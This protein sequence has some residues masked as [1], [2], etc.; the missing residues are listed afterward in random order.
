MIQWQAVDE[1][2]HLSAAGPRGPHGRPR[3]ATDIDGM[4][5]LSTMTVDR[6]LSTVPFM[7]ITMVYC[8]R[9]GKLTMVY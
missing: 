6:L 9:H 4:E 3:K 2:I 5:P 8:T 7:Y 1:D